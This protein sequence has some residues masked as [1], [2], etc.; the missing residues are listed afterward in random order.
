M[1][2]A[3]METIATHL[4]NA[5]NIAKKIQETSGKKLVDF[6]EAIPKCEDV[7]TEGE[8]VTQ[9]ARGFGMPGV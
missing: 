6:I 8:K 2:E 3:D 9:F 7:K 5:I 1:L 4:V